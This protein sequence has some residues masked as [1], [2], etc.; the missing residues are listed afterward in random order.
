MNVIVINNIT[1]VDHA[2]L[3]PVSAMGADPSKPL[4][5][6]CPIV[7]NSLSIGA[8]V[9]GAVDTAEQVVADFSSVKSKIKALLD[10]SITGFDHKLLVFPQDAYVG[11]TA[12]YNPYSDIPTHMLLGEH[13]IK[14][15]QDLP[16]VPDYDSRYTSLHSASCISDAVQG[17]WLWLNNY[18]VYNMQLYLNQRLSPLYVELFWSD[19]VLPC[20]TKTQ[21]VLESATFRYTHG[22][23]LSSSW[24]CR[25]LVHGHLSAVQ[26]LI[27]QYAKATIEAKERAKKAVET[28]ANYLDGCHFTSW[29]WLSGTK[30]AYGNEVCSRG[31]YMLDVTL[32]SHRVI[33]LHDEPTVENILNFVRSKFDYI[34]P[35]VDYQLYVTE[36]LWKGAS[37]VIHDGTPQHNIVEVAYTIDVPTVNKSEPKL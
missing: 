12:A 20:L 24:G 14:R 11:D 27:P 4:S 13:S 21:D 1:V 8:K 2:V 10:D 29:R 7:G 34:L 33:I 3:F 26:I 15:L 19:E 9:Y 5:A 25:N 6:D 30:I 16:S 17:D 36:G 23:P 31:D 35:D 32:F 22:L 37:V 18:I 28:I